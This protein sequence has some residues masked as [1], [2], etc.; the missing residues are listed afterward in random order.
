MIVCPFN[1]KEEADKILEEF[2]DIAKSL[3]IRH[4]LFFGTC[5][6]MVRDKGYIKGDNDIDVGVLC[7]KE[8]FSRLEKRL[9]ENGFIEAEEF[10][11]NQHFR[12][13]NIQIDIWYRLGSED[14]EFLKSF[15]KVTYNGRTYNIPHPVEDYLKYRYGN[16]RVPLKL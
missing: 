15:D 13:N 3:N 14:K 4:F 12:K 2:D 6:G 11:C 5:L 10:P 1:A 16:W 9:L 8:D 7:S